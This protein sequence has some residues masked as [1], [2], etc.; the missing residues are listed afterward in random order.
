MRKL[1]GILLFLVFLAPAGAQE[2]EEG[3]P[4]PKKRFW[5]A[6]QVMLKGDAKSAAELFRVLVKDHPESEFTDDS[7]YWMGRCCLR[8]KDKEPDAVVAFL[9]VIR[10]HA[11]SPFL[12]DAARE[13]MR[14]GDRTAVP[15]LR[16]RLAK[17]GDGAELT[18]K[19]LAEFDD[20]AGIR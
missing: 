5:E 4:D 3:P 6:R 10:E 14:L 19:A 7:L 11:Q 15:E 9:R 12:D 17:G 20:E 2:S 16:K 8:V 1:P 13:L 18:A